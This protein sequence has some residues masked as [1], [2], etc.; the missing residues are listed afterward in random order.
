MLISKQMEYMQLIVQQD[1]AAKV[2]DRLGTLDLAHFVDSSQGL[3]HR[4]YSK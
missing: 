2:F 4:P 1:C 3:F